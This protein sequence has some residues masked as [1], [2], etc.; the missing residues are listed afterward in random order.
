VEPE[1][2]VPASALAAA[3]AVELLGDKFDAHPTVVMNDKQVKAVKVTKW[4][5]LIMLIPIGMNLKNL[6]KLI[7]N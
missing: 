3:S 7:K 4:R 5:L 2:S 1:G 6:N